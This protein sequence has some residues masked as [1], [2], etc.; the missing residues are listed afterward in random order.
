MRSWY[1]MNPLPFARLLGIDLVSA[2]PDRVIGT[3][4]VREEFCTVFAVAHGGMIM[5]LADTLGALATV[6]NLPEDGRTTTLESKTNFVA[7]AAAGTLIK[8]ET[9]PVHRGRRSM[10]W[11]TRVTADDGRLIALVTQTQLVL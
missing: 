9:T 10:V 5:A 3:M 1:E 7:A 4:V 11:Q 6:A 8:G 2:A